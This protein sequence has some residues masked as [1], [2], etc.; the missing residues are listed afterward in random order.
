MGARDLPVA[1]QAL[2]MNEKGSAPR[3]ELRQVLAVVSR[4]LEDEEVELLDEQVAGNL[5]CSASTFSIIITSLFSVQPLPTSPTSP[6]TPTQE[7]PY[8]TIGTVASL[9]RNF[10]SIKRCVQGFSS[11]L[12]AFDIFCLG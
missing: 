3:A 4:P 5:P 10:V 2:A 11:F 7:N 12:D 9:P 8:R 1:R 6:T